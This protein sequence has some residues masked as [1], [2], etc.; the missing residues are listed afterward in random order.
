[1]KPAELLATIRAHRAKEAQTAP[2]ETA[3]KARKKSVDAARPV[4]PEHSLLKLLALVIVNAE[5]ASERVG[6]RDGR[7]SY[8]LERVAEAPAAYGLSTAEAAGLKR[9]LT[10]F[11][12]LRERNGEAERRRQ[13]P[14][15][16]AIAAQM[17]VFGG[18]NW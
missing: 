8:R 1:M 17:G 13:Q 18:P 4:T 16:D 14:M 6:C 10:L 7:V 15:P 2:V 9:L 3:Q 5:L 11:D 12:D